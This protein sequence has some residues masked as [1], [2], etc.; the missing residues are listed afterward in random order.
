MSIGTKRTHVFMVAFL[1]A[2]AHIEERENLD[3]FGM[4]YAEY[5]RRSKMFI[6]FVF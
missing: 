3:Y 6:P 2:T 5:M 4:K 1:A